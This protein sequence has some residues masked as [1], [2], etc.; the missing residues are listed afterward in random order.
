MARLILFNKPC[1][2]LSQFTDAAGRRT[3]GDFIDVEAVYP[4]GRLDYDSEG[5][6]LL[7]DDGALQAR[8]A[9][10]RHKMHKTYWLQVCGTPVA[11]VLE[12]LTTG[13][14]LRDGT[15]RA[16]SARTL[17]RPPALPPRDPPVAP[18]HAAQSSWIELVL[19]SGRN[20]EAR[21][22][23]AAVGHPVLR[24]V[25]VRIGPWTLNGLEPGAWRELRVHLAKPR[26]R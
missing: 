15:S 11:R 19:A 4:A 14:Q 22:M 1:R 12:R 9:H 8:I 6:L 23:L 20:R 17:R 5:L 3:L 10:P 25:R 18:R 7:T 21:R 16:L 13:V 24:L 2:V 26:P